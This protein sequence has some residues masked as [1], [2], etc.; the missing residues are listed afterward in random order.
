MHLFDGLIDI[1][2]SIIFYKGSEASRAPAPGSL[3]PVLS[4]RRCF[5]LA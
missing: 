2:K 1:K 4:W 5:R 3:F